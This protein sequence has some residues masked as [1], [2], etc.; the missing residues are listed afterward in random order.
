MRYV[1]SILIATLV[2]AA[3]HGQSWQQ[4][5]D[6]SRAQIFRSP[7]GKVLAA[8]R[9]DSGHYYA[10][11]RESGQWLD[12]QTANCPNC[13]RLGQADAAGIVNY[14]VD[15]S[16]TSS[17]GRNSLSSGPCPICPQPAGPTSVDSIVADAGFA[18]IVV[19]GDDQSRSA[20]VSMLRA[21]Y[22]MFRDC[23]PAIIQAYSPSAWQVKD[24]GYLTGPSPVV[25][26]L[27]ASG[28]DLGT[29]P[30]WNG[31]VSQV[32]AALRKADPNYKPAV[33]TVPALAGIL[34]KL[35]DAKT[36]ARWGTLLAGA[37]VVGVGYGVRRYLRRV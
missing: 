4:A 24:S 35:P 14:G 1:L 10:Y 32:V 22:G 2:I 17:F 37:L 30:A 33:P 7:S 29:F 8:Y 34:D 31:D 21:D 27:S 11:D 15:L 20:A 3:A 28:A 25:S 5:T 26:V 19:I 18:R 12:M 23:P 36:A 13:P 9:S 6:D 16:P